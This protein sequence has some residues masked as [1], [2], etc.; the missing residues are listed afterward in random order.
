MK[1]E[2]DRKIQEEK[3]KCKA[4]RVAVVMGSHVKEVSHKDCC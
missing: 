4:T 1:E 2:K 3:T